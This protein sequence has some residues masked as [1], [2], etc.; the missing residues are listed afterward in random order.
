MTKADLH[1]LVDEERDAVKRARE[2]LDRGE[3]IALE[4]LMAELD[5]AG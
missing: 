2:A 4:E 5:E 3:G 1:R